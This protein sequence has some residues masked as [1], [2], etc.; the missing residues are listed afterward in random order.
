MFNYPMEF[1][2]SSSSMTGVCDRFAAKDKGG[3][4]LRSAWAE[5]SP[6]IHMQN[7]LIILFDR[8][9]FSMT[10]VVATSQ[11]AYF[12]SLFHISYHIGVADVG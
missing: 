11:P 12:G 9:S 10:G 2:R 1:D 3:K 5:I 7:C 6:Y 4:G 8:S